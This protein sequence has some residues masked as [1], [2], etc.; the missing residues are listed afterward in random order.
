MEVLQFEHI[1]LDGAVDAEPSDHGVTPVTQGR[2]HV[3]SELTAAAPLPLVEAARPLS[4]RP[5]CG[6]LGLL[7]PRQSRLLSAAN[8][9]NNADQ[10]HQLER[11]R[12]LIYKSTV[13]RR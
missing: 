2:R 7:Q 13:L 1:L 3:R 10:R 12:Y 4:D 9:H 8:T 6:Q 5:T 11:R